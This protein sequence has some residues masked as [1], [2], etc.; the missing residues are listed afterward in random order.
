MGVI[1]DSFHSDG[2]YP[3]DSEEI[4]EGCGNRAGELCCVAF[5][6]A[7]SNRIILCGTGLT[8]DGG[9]RQIIIFGGE[10]TSSLSLS[11]DVRIIL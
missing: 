9:V 6:E 8:G 11:T 7:R 2:S 10:M 3:A 5:S 4:K 1:K